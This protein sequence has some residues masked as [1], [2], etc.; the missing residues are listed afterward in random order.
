MQR[1]LTLFLQN[2]THNS[3]FAYVVDFNVT[4]WGLNDDVKLSKFWTP[5]PWEIS[6]YEIDH[7]EHLIYV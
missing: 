5:G 6:P 3:V 7:N 1:I 2:I 4:S